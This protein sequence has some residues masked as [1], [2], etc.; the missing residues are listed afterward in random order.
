MKVVSFI[1]SLIVC[2]FS[3][4]QFISEANLR[5]H[6][7]FLASDKLEGREPC[8]KGEEQAYKYLQSEYKKLGLDPKGSKGYLQY[9]SY[10]RKDSPHDTVGNG[11]Q[12]CGTNIIGWL[13][14]G[15]ANTIVIGAHYDHL[16]NHEHQSSLQTDKKGIH[17]G[18]DDNASG[19]AGVLELARYFKNNGIVEKSNFLFICFSGEED[20]L[21]G[22]KFFTNNPTIPLTAISCMINMDMIGRLNDSTLKLSVFGVG[23][24][25]AYTQVFAGIQ[26][27]LQFYFDSSGVGPSDQTSFYLKNI[28]VLHFFSGQHSD[29]HKP[30]D[31]WEKINY[32][33]EVAILDVIKQAA[34][35]LADMEKI[36]FTPT[37]NTDQQRVSFKVTLG[38]M[39]DYSF[40]GKGVKVDGVTEGKPAF[41]AGIKSQDIITQLGIMPINSVYDYMKALAAYKKGESTKATIKRGN[42]TIEVNVEF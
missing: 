21:I 26:T 22:S 17:N 28:P 35:N 12:V 33:G 1:V 24:S 2:S 6:I 39:P 23:T 7:T 40:E 16:G 3:Y 41:K 10:K 32:K 29:Y 8:T 27:P 13:N 42:E 25:P 14:N 18:A 38:I 19:T 34:T 31:D 4:G 11:K 15:A 5:K 20:G 30:S 9:F 37:K 36:S